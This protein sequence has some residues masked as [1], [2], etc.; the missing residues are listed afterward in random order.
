MK[1]KLVSLRRATM[2]SLILQS[3]S[4]EVATWDKL[5]AVVQI[6]DPKFAHKIL[7]EC[8]DMLQDV[9]NESTTKQAASPKRKIIE[10]SATK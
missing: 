3:E 8:C 5:G 6:D 7:G 9:T 10:A 4:G 1:L 2:K